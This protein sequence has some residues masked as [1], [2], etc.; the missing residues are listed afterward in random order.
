LVDR[1]YYT[2][3]AIDDWRAGNIQ[4]GNTDREECYIRAIL[5]I[6]EEENIDTVFPSFDPQIYVFAKNKERFEK[7]GILIPVPGYETTIKP[8]D[9]F[10]TLLAAQEVGFPC[11]K[12]YL[13]ESENDLR[14]VAAELGFPLVIKPRFTS[15]GRGTAIVNDFRNLSRRMHESWQ[16][17]PTRAMVQEYIPGTEKQ[18]FYLV[19]D[20]AGELKMCFCPKTLRHFDRLYRNSSAASELSIPH[21]RASN[22]ADVVRKL[23]W[24]GGI[25]LQTK[26]DPRDGQPK[27]LETNPRLGHHLWYRTGVAINEPLMCLQIAKGSTVLPVAQYPFGTIFLSPVEDVLSFCFG[28]FDRVVYGLKRR[29]FA[30]A[31]LDRLSVPLSIKELIRSYKDTYL[32]KKRKVFD[33]YFTN[34]VEDP[35]VAL[36]WWLQFSH[37]VI[38]AVKHIGR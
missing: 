26:I 1:T 32:N 37:Q 8:L 12:T 9:K 16:I 4:S 22:A 23:G 5:R 25:T 11:P 20:R 18:Q 15:G 24:W 21:T 7:L 29:V 28:F 6:C 36:L 27:L 34:F 33:P 35:V 19:L 17:S 3:Y 30:T 13:P 38:S 14:K 2:P 10:Q 31:S